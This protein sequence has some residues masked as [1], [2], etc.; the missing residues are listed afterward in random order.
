MR[1]RDELSELDRV[2]ARVTEGWSRVLSSADDY[3]LDGVALNLHGFYG[4]LERIFELIAAVIDG[5][6]PKGENWHQALLRQMTTDVP[7]LRPAVISQGTYSRL[8]DYRGFRHVVRNVYAYNFE[9][10]KLQKLVKDLPETLAR[11]RAELLAFA[12]FLE[13]QGQD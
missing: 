7:G 9:T 8:D 6:K 5:A 3:Y 4:G 13:H 12:S 1:I 11:A 2:T 10:A